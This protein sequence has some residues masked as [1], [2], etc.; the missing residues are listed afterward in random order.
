[1]GSTADEGSE[2]PREALNTADDTGLQ[3]SAMA[4]GSAI[5]DGTV[6]H[7]P[8]DGTP[9]PPGT[10]SPKDVAASPSVTPQKK[11][12]QE[13]DEE[14][15]E[16][17]VKRTRLDEQRSDMKSVCRTFRKYQRVGGG[18]RSSYNCQFAIK[19]QSERSGSPTPTQVLGLD[20]ANGGHLPDLHK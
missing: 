15:V 11:P 20:Q 6:P 8:P 12:E 2:I 3:S 17:V 7:G 19:R 10:V 14:S 4:G 13:D 5:P 9:S 16:Q 1:M 18:I